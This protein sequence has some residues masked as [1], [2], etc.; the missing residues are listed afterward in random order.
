MKSQEDNE[1]KEEENLNLQVENARNSLFDAYYSRGNYYF[2][3]NDYSKA[4]DNCNKA[5]ELDPTD[6]HVYLMRGVSLSFLDNEEEDAG[7]RDIILSDAGKR[8]IMLAMFLDPDS[9]ASQSIAKNMGLSLA[10]DDTLIFLAT[11]ILD[12]ENIH[13]K[14]IEVVLNR[15]DKSIEKNPN[16]IMSHYLRYRIYFDKDDY[17]KALNAGDKIM[18]L[19][20]ESKESQ[21]TDFVLYHT[22]AIMGSIHFSNNTYDKAIEYFDKAICLFD[23]I[24][25]MRKLKNT[26]ILTDGAQ[27][28][29]KRAVSYWENFSEEGKHLFPADKILDDLD[30]AIELDKSNA[31]YYSVRGHL[32]SGATDK[33]G[34]PLI[35]ALT[36]AIEDYEKAIEIDPN[37]DKKQEI[38]KINQKITEQKSLQQGEP[39]KTF[40]DVI[41]LDD[42]KKRISE[43]LIDPL[44][45]PDIFEQSGIKP[46]GAILLYGPPRCGKTFIAE[47]AAGQ[48][49]AKFIREDSA[50][51]TSKWYGETEKMI[52]DVFDNAKS[53]A[54]ATKKPVVVFL[55]EV[56][57]LFPKRESITQHERDSVTQFLIEVDK[58]R[59]TG[60]PVLIIGATN[61][62]QHIDGAMVSSGR[63]EEMS[64]MP[65][66]G[67]EGHELR[68]DLFRKYMQ[69][70]TLAEEI[71]VELL[72]EKTKFHTPADMEKICEEVK[73]RQIYSKIEMIGKKKRK[74]E[75]TTTDFLE[76]IGTQRS[77]LVK[78]ARETLSEEPQI[79]DQYPKLVEL[80]KKVL[81]E[82]TPSD[83]EKIEGYR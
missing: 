44:K 83:D 25:D 14:I 6:P 48:C 47:S 22:L 28:Y 10:D 67:N 38:E 12:Y 68:I 1:N 77:S 73:R 31:F 43:V 51:L 18:K 35:D 9:T 20:S 34:K 70:S 39:T 27:V 50:T 40:N 11:Y 45:Y 30:K 69:P 21:N 61:K 41:G 4:I 26:G 54:K 24:K 80:A 75:I 7:K 78:W 56:D 5:I 15:L 46:G 76:V 23:K 42:V 17:D 82:T 37:I 8:D 65:P 3:K 81:E 72:A 62:P 59:K 49:K 57:A 13:E 33:N 32:Y 19:I 60:L 74:S 52:K 66:E 63:F 2:K 16:N 29:F 53:K 55:D 58:I 71:N 64:V 36:K 79:K